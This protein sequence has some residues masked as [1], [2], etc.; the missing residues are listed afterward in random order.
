MQILD[1][2]R[3]VKP[4]IKQ[5]AS[6]M[7]LPRQVTHAPIWLLMLHHPVQIST[8]LH[9]QNFKECI[10]NIE[11]IKVSMSCK[12]LHNFSAPGGKIFLT[13]MLVRY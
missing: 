4:H 12:L 11:K 9:F 7:L 13:C 2:A 3:T 5:H 10:T 1:C 8:H 6:F